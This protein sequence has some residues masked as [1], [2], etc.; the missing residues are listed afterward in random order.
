MLRETIISE[1]FTPCKRRADYVR[2]EEAAQ[3]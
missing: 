2:I 3:V 1:G